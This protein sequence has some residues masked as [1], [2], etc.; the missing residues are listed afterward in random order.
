MYDQARWCPHRGPS[1]TENLILVWPL[2]TPAGN[3]GEDAS[4]IAGSFWCKQGECLER[5]TLVQRC[6]SAKVLMITF[7]KVFSSHD[8]VQFP[9]SKWWHLTGSH[10]S[11]EQKLLRAL[12]RTGVEFSGYCSIW[13]N[14]GK[15]Q[16]DSV[17]TLTLIILYL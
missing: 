16:D 2:K 9:I 11:S 8:S 6:L 5:S 15:R 17:Q 1:N 3:H 14:E 7:S 12:T 13:H 10:I 4:I